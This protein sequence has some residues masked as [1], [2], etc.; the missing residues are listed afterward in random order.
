SVRR[1]DV[2]DPHDAV[3][4]HER[5]DRIVRSGRRLAE[6]FRDGFGLWQFE[7]EA[8][9]G[10]GQKADRRRNED[11][12]SEPA[13]LVSRLPQRRRGR[14]PRRRKTAPS[15]A[16]NSPTRPPSLKS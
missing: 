4:A 16:L 3:A 8:S 11:G 14:P 13:T 12:E 7:R 2:K 9:R 1:I 5:L 15:H 10:E 6:I